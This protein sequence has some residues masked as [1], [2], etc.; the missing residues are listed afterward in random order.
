MAAIVT[1]TTTKPRRIV[2]MSETLFRTGFKS[3]S[4]IY[5]L[6]K[7]G[8]FPQAVFITGK[9][10][11]FVESEIEAWMEARIAARPAPSSVMSAA[12]P[13]PRQRRISQTT[14]SPTATPS[15]TTAPTSAN[16]PTPR[17]RGPA[18]PRAARLAQ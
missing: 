8:R 11:G 14:A 17:R 16:P 4:T 1:D 6:M 9:A 18:R 10:I 3:R 15:P 12:P 13:R 5:D 7:A 2:R